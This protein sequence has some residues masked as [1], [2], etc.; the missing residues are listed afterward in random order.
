MP[1]ILIA[2]NEYDIATV[3]DSLSDIGNGLIP[4][5]RLLFREITNGVDL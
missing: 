5:K 2:E 3:D 4:L 1:D